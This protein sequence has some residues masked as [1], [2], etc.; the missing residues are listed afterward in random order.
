MLDTINFSDVSEPTL[1]DLINSGVTEGANIE[2]KRDAVGNSD[3]DKREFLKD[4]SAFANAAGGHLLIGMRAEEGAP[5]ELTGLPG[6]NP[7]AE[8]QRLDSMIRDNLEPRP[9][10]IQVRA[11]PVRAGAAIVVRVP[12]SWN[13]PHR[14]SFKG[15][16]KFFTRN[17]NG[18]H[19][20][21]VEE[22]RRLFVVS[23]TL[24]EAVRNFR[25]ERLAKIMANDTPVTVGPSGKVVVHVVP[26]IS[27]G[28]DDAI[29]PNGVTSK[30]QE[31]A[32]I[33]SS[34]H[35]LRVNMDGPLLTSGRSDEG[36]SPNLIRKFFATE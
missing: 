35:S 28:R 16:N 32:P 17:S 26:L 20:V 9:L 4:V 12:R 30:G 11:I 14:V 15:W 36:L 3:A 24:A 19:E 6:I 8:V 34:G 7:D 31:F 33:A 13:P 5:V 27:F 22:L 2:F 1:S 29:D 23:S 10:G 21:N 25:I 18:T